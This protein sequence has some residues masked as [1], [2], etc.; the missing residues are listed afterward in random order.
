[1]AKSDNADEALLLSGCLQSGPQEFYLTP[2]FVLIKRL[3]DYERYL[4]AK[5]KGA[6][7][8]VVE[9]L[10]AENRFKVLISHQR[11]YVR[12]F[13]MFLDL[14]MEA[15]TSKQSQD[16][17]RKL[18]D[19]L[20][21]NSK[22]TE[23]QRLGIA[24]VWLA[25]DEPEEI[26]KIFEKIDIEQLAPEQ[27]IAAAE[28]MLRLERPAQAVPILRNILD[29]EEVP[30]STKRKT[31]RLLLDHASFETVLAIVETD[32]LPADHEIEVAQKLADTGQLDRALA[33]IFPQPTTLEDVYYDASSPASSGRVIALAEISVQLATRGRIDQSRKLLEEAFSRV[34]E[35]PQGYTSN[36]SC[37]NARAGA[38][39]ALAK[40]FA[41]IDAL[42]EAR[43]TAIQLYTCSPAVPFYSP[44]SDQADLLYE[45]LDSL[46][47]LEQ[48]MRLLPENWQADNDR[49]DRAAT[50]AAF[51]IRIAELGAS[52]VA[53]RIADQVDYG[54]VDNL[55][56]GVPET[57]LWFRLAEEFSAQGDTDAALYATEKYAAFQEKEAA[58]GFI[59]DDSL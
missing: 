57:D 36:G 3:Y 27:M 44:T 46:E 55:Y 50:N 7:V 41:A 14:S 37:E 12:Y 15:A 30:A 58:S 8:A 31:S 22:I 49:T 28:L 11:E 33:I 4:N 43:N 10:L 13:D 53:I 51:A 25:L 45:I 42:E 47:T 32:E 34:E 17:A 16:T 6:A 40:G 5:L 9:Q 35:L 56:H 26:D 52:E 18:L 54:S 48:I 21:E 39:R 1:M 19:S 23:V 59:E 38:L 2:S 24:Q 20:Q 29:L